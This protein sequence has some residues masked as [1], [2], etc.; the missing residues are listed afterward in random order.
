MYLNHGGVACRWIFEEVQND[1][2]WYWNILDEMM[3]AYTE[4]EDEG[5]R[6]RLETRSGRGE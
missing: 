3:V 6:G 1:V 2:R 5:E 4:V